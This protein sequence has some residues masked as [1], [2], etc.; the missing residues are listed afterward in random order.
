MVE[1]NVTV[2]SEKDIRAKIYGTEQDLLNLL[3]NEEPPEPNN[4]R[5][6]VTIIATL[7][8]VLDE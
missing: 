8:W 6:K 1:T 7:R 4:Y 3:R 5:R 2:K